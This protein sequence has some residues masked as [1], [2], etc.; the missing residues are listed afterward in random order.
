MPAVS[1]GNLT[2]GRATAIVARNLKMTEQ[3]LLASFQMATE[4]DLQDLV[5]FRASILGVRPWNDEGYLQWR[6]G[7]GSGRRAYSKYRVLKLGGAIVAGIGAEEFRLET[8]T[9]SVDAACAM[10]IMS[11]ERVRGSGLGPWLNLALFQQYP[12]VLALG[13]NPNS[14][15]LVD[16]LFHKFEPR[17]DFQFPLNAAHSLRKRFPL[18][19]LGVGIGVFANCALRAWAEWYIWRSTTSAER[20][21]E[22]KS[23]AAESWVPRPAVASEG[24]IVIERRPDYLDW[25]YFENPREQHRVLGWFQSGHLGAYIVF[26][27]PRR[28]SAGEPL[29]IADWWLADPGDLTP[30]RALIAAVLRRAISAGSS[31]VKA[32]ASGAPLHKQLQ[33]CGLFRNS[34]RGKAAGWRSQP[35]VKSAI[36]LLGQEWCVTGLGDDMDAGRA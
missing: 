14:K 12:V 10:D 28:D 19:G 35:D 22:I 8:S 31:T 4:A 26:S 25:R 21:R 24:Q 23:F 27:E 9:G 20:I 17:R 1:A 5:R 36:P 33:Y 29:H 6:Y 11:L 2:F 7:L 30:L 15:G 18:A 3:E 16:M 13:A 34:I 32:Q